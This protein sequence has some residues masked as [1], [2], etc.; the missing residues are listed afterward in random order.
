M[1]SGS[2]W[3]LPAA[4]YLAVSSSAG[5]A[6]R[7]VERGAGLLVG[8]VVMAGSA[9]VSGV[10]S[11]CEG[12]TAWC[13]AVPW[14]ASLAPSGGAP[15]GS[16]RT[17]CS[18]ARRLLR[19]G[20]RDRP[21]ESGVEVVSLAH[22]ARLSPPHRM[23]IVRRC[24]RGLPP[25]TVLA[26]AYRANLLINPLVTLLQRDYSPL[27]GTDDAVPDNPARPITESDNWCGVR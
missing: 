22:R 26:A 13:W 6:D 24:S 16:G 3:F 23:P 25:R 7:L 2:P 4:E 1:G 19:A 5:C 10:W 15:V 9:G 12:A 11:C 14:V 20:R 21:D 18:P 8:T 17:P 27:R